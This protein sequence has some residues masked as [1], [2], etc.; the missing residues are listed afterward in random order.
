MRLLST[1]LK[2]GLYY[3]HTISIK[4]GDETMTEFE[5]LKLEDT[6]FLTYHLFL[7]QLALNNQHP[8]SVTLIKNAKSD[9]V[10]FIFLKENKSGAISSRNFIIPKAEA[11]FFNHWISLDFPEIERKVYS[12]NK[13]VK[14]VENN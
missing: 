11:A 2:S 1:Y 9:F 8:F 5:K 14:Q 12:D 4:Q 13:E 3:I 6:G 10:K 7:H